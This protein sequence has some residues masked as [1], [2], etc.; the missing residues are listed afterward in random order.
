[1]RVFLKSLAQLKTRWAPHFYSTQLKARGKRSMNEFGSLDAVRKSLIQ[2][3]QFSQTAFRDS[4]VGLD[5]HQL[6]A[7]AASVDNMVQEQLKMASCTARQMFKRYIYKNIST[8]LLC[9]SIS[10]LADALFVSEKSKDASDHPLL[11][12]NLLA[13]GLFITLSTWEAA[14]SLVPGI[15]IKRSCQQLK[16]VKILVDRAIGEERQRLA[17]S[18]P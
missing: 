4:L 18:I 8:L 6:N 14:I 10:T 7:L 1:M 12:V 16:G 5:E 2:P 13:T 17:A 3:A 9:I 15:T 11:L